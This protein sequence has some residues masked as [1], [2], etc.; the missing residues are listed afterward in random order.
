MGEIH[1]EEVIRLVE[2]SG[3]YIKSHLRLG[4]GDQA[5]LGQIGV[6]F[7]QPCGGHDSARF[8]WLLVTAYHAQTVLDLADHHRDPFDRLLIAQ[9]K[10]ESMR[11]VTYDTVLQRYLA[12]TLIVRK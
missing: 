3:A 7:C 12:D 2:T 5:S 9:A 1:D 8:A 4:N 10:Y 11:L 6:A